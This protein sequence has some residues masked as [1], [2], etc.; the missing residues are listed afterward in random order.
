MLFPDSG[1]DTVYLLQQILL[2]QLNPP[3]ATNGTLDLFFPTSYFTPDGV[4]VLLNCI[5]LLSFLFSTTSALFAASMQLWARRYIQLPQVPNTPSRRARVRSVLFLGTFKYNIHHAVEIAPTL[6]HLSVLLFN[7][8][9]VIYFFMNLSQLAMIALV[10]FVL[11]IAAYLIF[12]VLPC[13]DH[14]CPYSTPLSNISW[15]LWHRFALFTKYLLRGTLRRLRV[16]LAPRKFGEVESW[17]QRTFAQLL[18]RIGNDLNRHEQC[19]RDGLQ[20]SIVEDALRGSRDNDVQALN[21]LFQLPAFARKR[22]I[23][24]F[25]ASLPGETIIQLFTNPPEDGNITFREHLSALLQSCAP[26]TVGLDDSENTRKYRLLVCL[27]AVHRICRAS[28]IPDGA[29]L[30]PCLLNDLRVQFA[31]MPLMRTLW[32]NNDPAIRV[33]AR[34]ICALLARHLLR[35][36]SLD[37]QELAWLQDV[38][39]QPSWSEI[40]NQLNN[41]PALDDMTIDSF[42]YGVLS[43]QTDAL[44]IVQAT[45][46]VKT[47]AILMDLE[48]QAVLDK[49]AFADSLVSLIRRIEEGGHQDRDDVVDKLLDIFQDVFPSAGPQP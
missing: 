2:V 37:Q 42:V 27:G 6:L 35:Q 1:N 21:W 30:P 25:L 3:T 38:M 19:I 10:F 9:L 44:P 43:G 26:G 12:T 18:D 28:I 36:P 22:K 41:P 5:W 45:S 39:G 24:R 29:S 20:G 17:R 11:F 15:H 46:F 8:G 13:V 31:N 47:L 32:A 48:T 40:S 23:E 14:V 49:V 34:S 16:I 7:V 4:T 33:T